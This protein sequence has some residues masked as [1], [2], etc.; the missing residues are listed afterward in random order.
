[1]YLAAEAYGV[2]MVLSTLSTTSYQD[3]ADAAPNPALWMQLYVYK[4]RELSVSLIRKAEK[5]GYKAIV[6][7]VDTPQLG[8][9]VADVRHK[10]KLPRHLQLANFQGASGLGGVSN[11]GGSGL[12]AYVTKNI[13]NK[14][15]WGTVTWL[16]SVTKLPIIL[17]GILT[18]EDALETLKHDVQGIIVSNHGGRQLDGVPSAVNTLFIFL[19]S[20]FMHL[21]SR[22]CHSP[23]A[24]HTLFAKKFGVFNILKY[25]V[26][27]PFQILCCCLVDKRYKT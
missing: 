26:L 19:L 27:K 24:L 6:L 12:M 9:R 13:E 1:M 23:K 21:Y 16:R 10:F 17:K 18:R 15:D 11:E 20:S 5:A 7:T 25:Y 8:Q 3:V 4:K 14:L 2:C 22:E